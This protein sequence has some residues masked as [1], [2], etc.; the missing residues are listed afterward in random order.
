MTH[1]LYRFFW[2][3]NFVFFFTAAILTP[4]SRVN[5]PVILIMILFHSGQGAAIVHVR[6]LESPRY[7]KWNGSLINCC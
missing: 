7:T 4:N 1:V 5:T 6:K 2:Y 3:L